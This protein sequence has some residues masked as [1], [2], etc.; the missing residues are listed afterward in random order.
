MEQVK[1]GNHKVESISEN[2]GQKFYMLSDRK[3]YIRSD[4]VK[5]IN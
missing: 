1:P 3:E 5:M 4:I 2:V